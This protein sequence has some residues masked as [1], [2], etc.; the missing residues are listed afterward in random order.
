LPAVIGERTVQG[1][2]GASY[3]TLPKLYMRQ[4]GVKP[5]TVMEVIIE[6]DSITY[7]PKKGDNTDNGDS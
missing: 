7:R 4:H 6:G 3:V 5:G 1:K 2:T